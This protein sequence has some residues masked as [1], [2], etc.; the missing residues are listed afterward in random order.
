M[1]VKRLLIASFVLIAVIAVLHILALEHDWYFL[2]RW[3]D[4]IVHLLGGAWIIVSIFW[5]TFKT[6]SH[7][8]RGVEAEYAFIAL[9]SVLII[10]IGWELFEIWIGNTSLTVPHYWND[11]ISDLTADVVGGA[12]A[13]ILVLR[14]KQRS[15]SLFPNSHK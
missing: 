4:F 10:S 13:Y 14:A 9:L 8:E 1:L 7:F 3:L 5:I 6:E 2:Y 15:T 12:I 11:T